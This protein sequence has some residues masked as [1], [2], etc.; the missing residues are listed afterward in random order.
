[1]SDLYLSEKKDLVV[2]DFCCGTGKNSL[3]LSEKVGTFKKV[4]LVDI[5]ERF[6]EIAKK[7]KI[8]AKEVVL[9]KGDILKADLTCEADAVISLF[10]YHHVPDRAKGLYV[11][12]VIE[13]LKPGGLL[14]LGEIYLPTKEITS[15]YY[16]Y[17][18]DTIPDGD[19]SDSL[20]T[21]LLQ[22]AE[23]SDF[24]FKVSQDFA[25]TQ[26]KK[27]NF[28]LLESKK[29]WPTT[30]KFGDDIGMFFE[31]WKLNTKV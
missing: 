22:T 9:V 29:I 17:L 18:T 15:E 26:L 23:S 5:N 20:R 10:A 28:T 7:S 19:M 11:K 6:L 25:H 12:K 8:N 13:V 24:E 3:L 16:K 27:N 30:K 21:F 4:I 2:A 1:S 31:V 14:L